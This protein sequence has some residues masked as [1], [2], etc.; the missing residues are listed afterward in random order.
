[1]AL[2]MIRDN[3][4][5][6]VLMDVQM[7]KMDGYETTKAIRKNQ[8]LLSLPIIAMT[9]NAMEGDE[10]KCTQAGMNGYISKPINQKLLLSTMKKFIKL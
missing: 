9:A 3:N 6:L 7:P 2:N 4:Y 8:N 10:K 5:D 1:M